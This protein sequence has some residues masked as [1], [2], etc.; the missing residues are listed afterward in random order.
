MTVLSD[1]SAISK[2]GEPQALQTPAE[3]GEAQRASQRARPGT[4][5]ASRPRAWGW[6][7][8]ATEEDGQRTASGDWPESVSFK[9]R[10][11]PTRPGRS[12]SAIT[13]IGMCGGRGEAGLPLRLR[14][15]RDGGVR[16]VTRVTGR[17][18]RG[19]CQRRVHRGQC[20][21]H[22]A[23]QPSYINNAVVSQ[24]SEMSQTWR[25]ICNKVFRLR[26]SGRNC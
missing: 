2:R 1:C 20:R 8:G 24:S 26:V 23:G 5:P 10:P 3:P 16:R 19:G 11:R 25:L 7:A 18:P 15:R 17:T 14:R 22:C 13:A 9:W 6:A 4:F 12:R 21:V